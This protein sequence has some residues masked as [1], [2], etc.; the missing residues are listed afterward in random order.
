MILK[1]LNFIEFGRLKKY[2][3]RSNSNKL[4]QYNIEIN[5]AFVATFQSTNTGI[6]LLVDT[7]CNIFSTKNLW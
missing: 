3:N 2:Y 4:S 7:S 5:S 6:R 1:K